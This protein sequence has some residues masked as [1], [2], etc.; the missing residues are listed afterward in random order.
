[1]ICSNIHIQ[2]LVVE[3]DEGSQVKYRTVIP[4]IARSPSFVGVMH[5]SEVYNIVHQMLDARDCQLRLL[6]GE[7]SPGPLRYHCISGAF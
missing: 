5:H 6:R 3:K 2:L 7:T 1:M 4:F